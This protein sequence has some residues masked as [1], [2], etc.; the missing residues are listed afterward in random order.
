M[1]SA[2]FEKLSRSEKYK[3][4]NKTKRALFSTA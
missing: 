2:L 3:T 4:E 1:V